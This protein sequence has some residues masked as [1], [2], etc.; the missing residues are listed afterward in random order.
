MAVACMDV[1]RHEFGLRIP[2]DLSVVGFDDTAPARW[3]SYDLTTFSQPLHPMVDATVGV[4]GDLIADPRQPPR[5]SVVD[6]ELIVRSSARIPSEGVIEKEG[7]RVWRAAT[8][9]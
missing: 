1:A 7:R 2:D 6:G 4:L 3:R 9:S 5:R 8:E